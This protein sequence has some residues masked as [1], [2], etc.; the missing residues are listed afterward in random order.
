[1]TFY[2]LPR[3]LT[4][5][6]FIAETVRVIMLTA[7]SLGRK[8]NHAGRPGRKPFIVNSSL[9]RKPDIA[10]S[11]GG[12]QIQQTFSTGSENWRNSLYSVLRIHICSLRCWHVVTGTQKWSRDMTYLNILHMI[13]SCAKAEAES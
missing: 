12:S 6:M 8:H 1:M 9:G 2:F 5:K 7:E 13:F 3:P 4:A 11:L 10:D